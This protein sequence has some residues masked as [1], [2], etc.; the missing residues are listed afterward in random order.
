M[1]QRILGVMGVSDIRYK[2][3]V[4]RSIFLR[5]RPEASKNIAKTLEKMAFTKKCRKRAKFKKG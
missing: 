4:V 3:A 2:P 5:L 1:L